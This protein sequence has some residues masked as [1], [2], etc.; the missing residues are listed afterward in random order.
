MR[1]YEDFI[2]YKSGVYSKRNGTK[3]LGEHAI[4]LVGFGIDK[5][6][7]YWRV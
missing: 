5:G 6:V 2:H 1:V 3:L 4:M 7:H